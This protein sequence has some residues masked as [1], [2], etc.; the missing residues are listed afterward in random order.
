MMVNQ[1]NQGLNSDDE[2]ISK[3][4]KRIGKIG[5][6]KK[7]RGTK[8]PVSEPVPTPSRG[9]K[10]Q[11][12]TQVPPEGDVIL[13]HA[14][15]PTTL[16]PKQPERRPQQN[17]SVVPKPASAEWSDDVHQRLKIVR[18]IVA[19]YFNK[20]QLKGWKFKCDNAK[21]RLG[22]TNYNTKTISVSNYFVREKSVTQK[23]V[24]NTILHEI[25]HALVG[26]GHGHDNVWRERAIQIGCDGKR[27]S[28]DVGELAPPKYIIQCT[29][30]GWEYTR[31]KLQAKM[32]FQLLNN[33]RVCGN[34][35][36]PKC[37]N[38]SFTIVKNR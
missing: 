21:R 6:G 1:N 35:T 11:V 24:E 3:Y 38:T 20:H 19:Y 12:I 37:K 15:V 34:R 36:K 28:D 25:A 7:M 16:V 33:G 31:D 9:T 32:R 27:C 5:R 14:P 30:C 8:R 18:N 2:A 10:R 23:L 13:A 22:L 29:R 4:M 26:H 17:P